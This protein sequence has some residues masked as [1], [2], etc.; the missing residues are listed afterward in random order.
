M[1]TPVLKSLEMYLFEFIC[2]IVKL[3]L[4]DTFQTKMDG[5]YQIEDGQFDDADEEAGRKNHPSISKLAW[6][7]EEVKL[8]TLS[9][10]S[11]E[12]WSAEDYYSGDDW[13]RDDGST[14]NNQA[15]PNAQTSTYKA[16]N[17][18]PSDKLFKNLCNKINV[19]R[20]EGP[21]NLSGTAVNKLIDNNKKSFAGQ[22]RTK[23]KKDRATAEQVMDPRTRM[24][25]FK[26][27]SRHAVTEV[28]GC[29]ST[30][31]EANVYHALG[32]SGA[33]LAIKVY[34]TSIL[35]F[36]VKFQ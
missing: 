11:E 7:L 5:R 8:S 14:K 33:D 20:Y 18:Q 34:K 1:H 13:D 30:G 24:V 27:L 31:K 29:I 28:N 19:E 6:N 36:K 9:T 10:S 26:L 3:M 15:G 17:Y 4:F 16:S 22:H 32:Q 35:V 23:D 21:S 12:D 25:L 2:H